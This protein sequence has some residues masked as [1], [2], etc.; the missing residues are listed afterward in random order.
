MA[1]LVSDLRLPQSYARFV[2]GNATKVEEDLEHK[3][4]DGLRV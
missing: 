4:D 3:Y 1:Y 2:S